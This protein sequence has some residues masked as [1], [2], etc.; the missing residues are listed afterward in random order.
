MSNATEGV[1]LMEGAVIEILRRQSGIRLDPHI[2]NSSLIY[3]EVG[4]AALAK[5][6]LQ[7]LRI[8]ESRGLDFVLM[9]P[10]WRAQHDRIAR[11]DFASRNVIGDAARFVRELATASSARVRVAGLT[12][13]K[14]DCYC[15]EEAP[16]AQE[17]EVYHRPHLDALAGAGVDF[18]VA[19]TL[20]ALREAEGL[21]SAANK[22]G[23]RLIPSFVLEPGGRLLDGT[24]LDDA[25]SELDTDVLLN[26]THWSF[27]RRALGG[28]LPENLTRVLG[29]Q[30][31]TA[32]CHP[33]SLEGSV[34]P[35][36]EDP[37]VFA[38]G[39][40]SLHRDFGLRMLGGCCGTGREH[41]SALAAR[42]RTDC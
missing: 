12:G 38:E 24:T 5:V 18:I 16:S 21:V 29:L 20:P 7:Y 8:A 19:A 11:S 25:I 3:D 37:Q 33:R 15:P 2:A 35:V 28:V 26:C 27:A 23:I 40:V 6:Q 22:T 13:P 10:T 39:M 41:I 31:N 42:L 32:A 30:A 14:G 36:T 34:E 9:T 17:A 1:V 4:S